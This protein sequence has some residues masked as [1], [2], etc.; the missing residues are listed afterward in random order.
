MLAD[1]F[2]IRLFPDMMGSTASRI[3]DP[4]LNLENPQVLVR[5][6][7]VYC[8]FRIGCSLKMLKRPSHL[9]QALIRDHISHAVR[10]MTVYLTTLLLSLQKADESECV[11]IIDAN[12]HN[13]V[14]IIILQFNA[15]CSL[16]CF[17]F[18]DFT[19]H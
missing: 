7:K 12:Y 17:H 11:L 2:K 8:Q 4:T 19:L 5:Y 14:N 1:I 10:S 3:P 16:F 18:A 6:I 9:S 15:L 13:D